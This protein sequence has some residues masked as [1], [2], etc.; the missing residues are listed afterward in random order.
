MM[1]CESKRGSLDLGLMRITDY[2]AGIS[3]IIV[4]PEEAIIDRAV[5]VAWLIE[6]W[7]NWV[8]ETDINNIECRHEL[9]ASEL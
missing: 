9:E 3:P 6:N 4:F 8:W 1:I 2:D 7:T 5:S